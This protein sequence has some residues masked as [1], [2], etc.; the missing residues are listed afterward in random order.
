M[1]FQSANICAWERVDDDKH[2]AGPYAL[3]ALSE[4]HKTPTVSSFFVGLDEIGEGKILQ[5]SILFTEDFSRYN[6]APHGWEAYGSGDLS[7]TIDGYAEATGSWEAEDL[8]YPDPVEADVVPWTLS[9]LGE[10]GITE[11]WPDFTVLFNE[12]PKWIQGTGIS[13]DSAP[14]EEYQRKGYATLV[15]KYVPLELIADGGATREAAY[16]VAEITIYVIVMTP[17][18]YQDGDTVYAACN[19][20]VGCRSFLSF[21]SAPPFT[22]ISFAEWQI[23]EGSSYSVESD[24]GRLVTLYDVGVTARAGTVQLIDHVNFDEIIGG[25]YLGGSGFTANIAL[26]INQYYTGEPVPGI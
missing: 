6:W 4:E 14:I 11:D 26:Q 13:V 8:I 5:L 17:F 1:S 25:F 7:I 18:I 9:E 12:R 23:L 10:T 15:G 19:V 2:I 3:P 21:D 22:E 24:G 16:V 20:E